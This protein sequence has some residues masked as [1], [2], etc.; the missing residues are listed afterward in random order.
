MAEE[1]GVRAVRDRFAAVAGDPLRDPPGMHSTTTSDPAEILRWA[2]GHDAQP[3]T[4]EASPSGPHVRSVNDG[5]AGIRFNFPGFAPF[6]PISWEEWFAHFRRHDL[7]FVFDEE[8][9]RA[10]TERAHER[11]V[12]RGEPTGSD[13]EDWF[14]A[15]RDLQ[16]TAGTRPGFRYRLIK[17]PGGMR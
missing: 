4:G 13:W 12:A 15:E 2:E 8:D 14:G 11:W 17:R 1:H 5:D 16:L 3:A 10:V 7:L 6:R 9:T